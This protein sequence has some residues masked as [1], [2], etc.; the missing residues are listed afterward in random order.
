MFVTYCEVTIENTAGKK[1][2]TFTKVN[3][4]KITNSAKNLTDTCEI[5]LPRRIN[6]LNGNI[7]DVVQRGA[8]VTVKLGYDLNMIEE[9]NGYVS[10][11]TA[12]IPFIIECEDQMW[13]LKQSN[14]TKSFG[15]TKVI[16]VIKHIWDGAM[17]VKDVTI[18]GL[19]VRNQSGAEVLQM[20]KKYGLRSYFKSGVLVVSFAAAEKAGNRI[21]YNFKRNVIDTQ[22]KYSRQDDLKI[23]VKG[24]SKFKDGKIIEV[25]AGDK[26]GKLRTLN[27]VNLDKKQLEQYVKMDIEKLK[28]DGYKGTFTTFG[29][30][31]IRPADTAY[32]V[33]PDWPERSG[34][35]Q[36]ESVITTF[37]MSGFRRE[38]SPERKIG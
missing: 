27:Y 16:E 14:F 4:I 6:I 15:K 38:V 13:L 21:D 30:P 20:L 2:L 31:F 12:D 19:I 11:V 25:F 22:L 5:R 7:N 3:E 24:I 32:L 29:T 9:F 10:R 33:D 35:Y 36:V 28:F 34:A 17:E 37:N 8:K 1:A 26:N 23:R 18:G